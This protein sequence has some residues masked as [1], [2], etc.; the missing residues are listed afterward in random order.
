MSLLCTLVIDICLHCS[1][2]SA[3]AEVSSEA[4]PAVVTE[5]AAATSATAEESVSEEEDEEDSGSD[6]SDESDEDLQ[7]LTEHERKRA[8]AMARIEV[9]LS[10]SHLF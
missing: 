6:E 1:A 2:V 10:T 4:S 8:K 5:P 3:S 9:C 7:H